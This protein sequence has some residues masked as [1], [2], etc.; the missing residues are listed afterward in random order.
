MPEYRAY[1]VGTDGHILKATELVCPN[2]EAAKQYARQL[3]DGHDVELFTND[4]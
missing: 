1:M 3:V 4:R 2:D